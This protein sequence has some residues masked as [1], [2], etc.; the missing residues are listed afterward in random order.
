MNKES[1]NNKKLLI[2]GLS[3]LCLCLVVGLFAYLGG[4]GG[5]VADPEIIDMLPD[6]TPVSVAEIEPV[7]EPATTPDVIEV[8]PIIT[9]QEDSTQEAD[10]VKTPEEATPPES[11]LVEDE[12][13]LVNPA[14][15]PTYTPEQTQPSANSGT[16]Q[17]GDTNS[18]G[19][20]WVPGFGWVTPTN[21][22]NTQETA[23]NAG[24]GDPVG[25]M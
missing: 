11:P 13:E 18:S 23:P 21:E 17:G 7:T 22:P 1:K 5:E 25:D 2:A 12:E 3:A 9:P 14:Q 10:R 15:T 4:M 8:Q 24:T 16:P 19:Q 20:V 6:A